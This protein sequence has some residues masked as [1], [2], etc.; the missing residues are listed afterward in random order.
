M[1]SNPQPTGKETPMNQVDIKEQIT[2][3]MASA[4]MA[5]D[6]VRIQ[7]DYKGWRIAVISSDFSNKPRSERRSIALQDLE[8]ID[9]CGIDLLTPEEHEWAGALPIDSDLHNLPLWAEALAKAENV[10]TS[11]TF[12]SDLDEDLS[13]P[14]VVTFYSLRGGVGRSTA[15]AYTARILASR[16][17]SVLCVDMDLEAPGLASLFGKESE[18]TESQ[19]VVQILLELEQGE[20]PDITKH[21]LR[22]SETDELYCLPAGVPNAGYAR[23][24]TFIEPNA[25]YREDKNPLRELLDLLSTSMPFVP[26]VILLDSRTGIN[27]LSG[28]LLFDIADLAIIAFFPHPQAQTGT[29]ALVKAL[30]SAKTRRNNHSFTPEP[31]FLISPVPASKAPEIVSRYRNRSLEWIAEWL[32]SLR[33]GHDGD[34]NFTESEMAHFVPYREAVATSDQI[35]EDPDLWRD[36]APV[37]EWIERF[38]PTP[39]EAKTPTTIAHLKPRVLQELY[40]STGTAEQQKHFRETFVETETVRKAL[41]TRFPLVLGRKGT[42]KTAVFRRLLEDPKSNPIIVVAPSQLGN[43]DWLLRAEGFQSIE[44]NLSSAGIDWRQIWTAYI[45]LTVFHSWPFNTEAPLPNEGIRNSVLREPESELEIVSIL[46]NLFTQPMASLM[47]SDWLTRL[48]K[49]A[50]NEA[51]LLFDGLDTGFGHSP[52]DRERRHRAIEGLFAFFTDRGDSL[53]K[54]RLKVMLREDIWRK[55]QFENKSHLFG[56]SVRLAWSDKVD[57]FKVVINQ[58]LLS[59]TFKK[60][61]ESAT[62][63]TGLTAKDL[64]S[65]IDAE[66]LRAWNVLVGERMKGGKTTFTRNWVWNRLADG[67]DDHSPRYLLQLFHQV[68]EWERTE[69]A[70]N[71]YE[72]SVIRPRGL[73]EVLPT[74][75]EEVLAALRDEEFPELKPLLDR[76]T[77]IGRTPVDA[78]EL[79]ENLQ[80]LTELA[81]EVGLL[82]IYEGTD[83][84]VERYKVPEIHRYGLKMTRRGQA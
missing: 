24:L 44:A 42:G 7:P 53:K 29:S 17:R 65:W 56:R 25:W 15:L 76:L 20:K 18:V 21:L 69:Q 22:I 10:E 16:G 60:L 47:I 79:E 26:D 54:L 64:D 38:L 78:R 49:A 32:S 58:A 55:L 73:I 84:N 61:L 12:P 62:W 67:N 31:R 36:Y 75:S 43:K 51:T 6:D 39:G 71:P 81:R 63:G 23:L 74:V 34:P 83:E 45:C 11:V 2:R 27:Q 14:I 5:L 9:I 40:F 37:A 28:P 68:T 59:D 8:S 46:C 57:Y 19:G 52:A 48:D 80:E 35:L 66:V 4:N 72:R 13:T 30:L 41:T 77:M 33:N 82:G 3:N 50:P 70:K 1:D